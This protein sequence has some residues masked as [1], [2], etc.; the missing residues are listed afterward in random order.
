M[1][2]KQKRPR[3]R[4]LTAV[5]EATL[6][7]LVYPA[8]IIGKRIRVKLDGSRLIKIH[9]DKTQ[10]TQVEH[11]IDTFGSLYKK[12]TGKDVHFEFREVLV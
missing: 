5:H 9:L 6:N 10:Q 1:A 3:S 11:K 7:D 4:T 12:L 8:E 2:S